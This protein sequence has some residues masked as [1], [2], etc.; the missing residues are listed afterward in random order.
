MRIIDKNNYKRIIVWSPL[1]LSGLPLKFYT[2]AC[3]YIEDGIIKEII[4][5]ISLAEFHELKIKYNAEEIVTDLTLMPGMIDCHVHLSLNG[6][7][8]QKAIDEWDNQQEVYLRFDNEFDNY[9]NAGVLA[10]RDGGDKNSLAH[11]YKLSLNNE[12]INLISTGFAIYK[13]GFYGSFLGKGIDTIDEVKPLLDE[14][15]LLGVDQIKIIISG[16]VSFKEYG[17]VGKVQWS[18]N[19]LKEI[20]RLSHEKGLKVMG[21]ASSHEAVSLA[22]QAGVDTIEHGY[23]LTSEDLDAMAY[24][25]IPW[26]P[27][28]IPVA[29]QTFSHIK[30][31]YSQAEIDV[32]SRTYLRHLEKIKEGFDSG[33]II[34]I[35][36][37]AGAGGVLHGNSYFEELSLLS[38]SGINNNELIKAATV[39]G[40]IITGT[41]EYLGTIEIGK[42]AK[43][44]GVIGNPL[45]N[46]DTLKD[47]KL[48]I[49]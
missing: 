33:V 16:I 21:H 34:G 3:L 30:D 40:S 35:G 32:I 10:V 46:L 28:V 13:K 47:V 14:L 19:E 24:N 27:T 9:L 20:T 4:N 42:R 1:I 39:N 41:E 26:I 17:K 11:N 25:N 31:N 15:L 38:Q 6:I 18:L 43:L 8:F 5:N 36:T 7:N 48:T 44:L 12:K 49:L 29:V 23:F 37:D 45:E 2:K 22:I